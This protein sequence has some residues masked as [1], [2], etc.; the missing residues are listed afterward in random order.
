MFDEGKTL[1]KHEVIVS[2]ALGLLGTPLIIE[3]IH[4]NL[5]NLAFS[6]TFAISPVNFTGKQASKRKLAKVLL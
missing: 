2:L 4:K 3:K 6:S 5:I 1:V